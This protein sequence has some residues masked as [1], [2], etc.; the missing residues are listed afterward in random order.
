MKRFLALA[1]LFVA[2]LASAQGYIR[3]QV[4]GKQICI[5]WDR[6][7]YTYQLDAAGYSRDSTG[8]MPEAVDAAFRSWQ[9]LSDWCSGFQF[10]KG[11][12]ITNPVIGYKQGEDNT[13]VITFRELSCDAAVPTDDACRNNRTCAN[14]YRCWDHGDITIALTTATFNTTSGIILDADIEFNA[15]AQSDG[16]YFSFTTVAAPPCSADNISQSCVAQDVQNTLTHEIGHVIGLDHVPIS[17]AT[18]EPSAPSGETRKR[19]IDSGTGAGL[20]DIYPRA[21]PSSPTCDLEATLRK[22]IQA[23]SKGSALF[24]STGCT[25]APGAASLSGLIILFGMWLG[26]SGR[27]QKG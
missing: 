7:E 13:N 18:M 16:Q 21:Q 2:E 3:T 8:R 6:R 4:P 22:S 5:Y 26:L 27:R 19:I 9:T 12:R 15:A 10:K 14:K 23:T 25:V 20:C 17:G 1:I 11:A 24:S